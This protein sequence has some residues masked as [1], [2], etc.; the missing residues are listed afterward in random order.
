MMAT[1]SNWPRAGLVALA[2]GALA[3][4]LALGY[5]L[6]RRGPVPTS[7]APSDGTAAAPDPA[8]SVILYW[9]DPMVPD[10]HFDKPGKSPFMDMQ[11]IAKRAGATT[12]AGV[13]VSAGV[14]QNL[15]IRTAL[16]EVG[17]GTSA[18][19]IAA[20]TLQWDLHGESRVSSRVEGY[21]DQVYVRAP[22]ERVRAGQPLAAIVA[23]RLASALA[24]YRALAAS[25]SSDARSV[26]AAARERLRVLGLS[27]SDARAAAG[28]APHVVLRAPSDGVLAE[29]NVRVGD[30]VSPG[31]P[32][33]RLN[34]T[35]PLWM[36][37]RVPQAKVATVLRGAPVTVRVSSFPGETFAGRVDS[38]LPQIDPQ[39]RT[40]TLR[41]VLDN[42]DS[43][44]VA[45]MF[46]EAQLSRSDAARYPW[47]PSEALI[48]T[49]TD[50]RVI[51]EKDGAFVPVRVS[52]GQSASGRTEI[53]R[54]LVGGERVVVSG[55]F[56]LD[57][58]ASLSGALQRLDDSDA[59][60]GQRAPAP[61]GT[62][63]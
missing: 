50:A 44:L 3:I 59:A 57:S 4:A 45:G 39:T 27:D 43:R 5:W 15:G 42:R 60:A 56:L 11:L 21:V 12:A 58:E 14:R 32:L 23:P 7:A 38:L 51:V 6:G 31:Q 47:V 55:Q 17:A 62:P 36:E 8:G 19:T 29:I 35:D 10:Q 33:F 61:T 54:G 53:L 20:G 63:P 30:N 52:T 9:Y 46:A 48:L 28:G 26:A 2:I 22:F 13:R 34:A 16:V 24:E 41:I 18:A 25:G 49:G 40:Q 1:S 37:A